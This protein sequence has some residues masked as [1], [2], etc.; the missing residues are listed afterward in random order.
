MD[1]D[2]APTTPDNSAEA[3]PSELRGS[4]VDV[5]R[6]LLAENDSDAIL[7]IVSKLVAENADM[8][9]RLAQVKR[10]FKTSEKIGRAQLV[11]FVDALARGEREAESEEV[12]TDG[13]DELEEADAMLRTASGIDDKREE[14]EI[15]KR[16]TR[17]PRQPANRS[18]VPDHVRRVDNPLLVPADRRPCPR[19]GAER[20]CIGHEI[21]EVIELI[22]AEV[23][24]RRD[25]REKLACRECDAEIVRAPTGDKVVASGKIGLGLAAT[26]LVEKYVD[27]LPLHR[28]RERLARL[29]LDIAVSTLSDQIK[30][31]T[32]LLRPLW[33]AALAECIAARV[34]HLDGTGLTVLDGTTPGNKKMGALWGY[35]GVNAGD[36]IAAYLYMST[37]KATAQR[38]GELGPQ[39]MLDLREGPTVADASGLFDASFAKEKLIECGCNMHARRYFVKALDAGDKRAAL[40]I[41]A[42][43]KLYEIERELREQGVDADAV[44][45]QRRERSKL[46]WDEL[47]SWCTVHKKHE[48]PSSRLGIALRYFTNH[49]VALARFLDYGYV[50]MDNGIVERLHV[51]TAMTR[52]NYLFAGSDGGAERAAIAY[53]ILGSCRLAGIDPLEYLRDVLPRLTRKV[54]LIDLSDLLPHRWKQ[55]R[56]AVATFCAALARLGSAD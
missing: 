26:L 50:P 48:P 51:R 7:Q 56:D 43:K 37:G 22:P 21:T 24:V 28:Q 54:R 49:R 12:D 53:T 41:A 47:V 16:K 2:A 35:V 18:S 10:S 15:A 23:V 55:R 31:S 3:A 5:V 1:Q 17:P 40:P 42:Y 27:G 33:R 30:W 44:L 19:C 20:T 46:L 11:L 13:P 34:M 9:R 52:K 45:A 38:P 8:S 36:V 25:L 29:G 4:V 32:D 6:T 14:D 39:D